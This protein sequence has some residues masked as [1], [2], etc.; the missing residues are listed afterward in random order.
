MSSKLISDAHWTLEVYK[1]RMTNSAWRQVLLNEGDRIIVK[2]IIRQLVAKSLGSGVVEVSK[3]PLEQ[4]P[5]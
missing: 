4:E 5:Q 3:A 1:Q 2:G